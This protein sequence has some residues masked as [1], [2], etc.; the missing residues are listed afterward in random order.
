MTEWSPIPEGDERFPRRVRLSTGATVAGAALLLVLAGVALYVAS[1]RGAPNAQLLLP[2]GVLA[3]IVLIAVLAWQA[4]VRRRD[5]L[6]AA[7]H[8]LGLAGQ[9]KP[10]DP[11]RQE[12]F[13]PVSHLKALR[14]GHRGV[15]WSAHGEADGR[16]MAIVEH[17]YVVSSGKSSHVLIHTVVST[18]CPP[19]WPAVTL[20]PEHVFTSWASCWGSPIST[21]RMRSSTGDGA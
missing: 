15:K 6:R 17:R 21:S 1:S 4:E 3:A 19:A 18:P 16:P 2:L 20:S 8:D 10:D 14:H 11:A 5:G 7:C 9:F 12:A 13:E